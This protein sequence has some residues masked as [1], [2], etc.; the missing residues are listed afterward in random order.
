MMAKTKR[1]KYQAYN[2]FLLQKDIYKKVKLEVSL[3]RVYKEIIKRIC[4]SSFSN[5]V[6]NFEKLVT[7]KIDI[8]KRILIIE[9]CK[10]KI[11]KEYREAVF[12]SLTNSNKTD[13]EILIKYNLPETSFKYEKRKYLYF[14]AD[15]HGLVFR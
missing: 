12:E 4:N 10:L 13:Q 15:E 3:Y 5:Q 7:N 8:E 2:D 9:E 1:K 11:K 6:N 14:I